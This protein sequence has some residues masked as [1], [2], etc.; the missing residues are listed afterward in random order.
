MDRRRARVALLT[1]VGIVLATFALVALP[2]GTPGGVGLAQAATIDTSDAII[3]FGE[4]IHVAPGERVETAVSFGGNILVEGTVDQAVV[5]F[6][7]NVD[8]RPG[9]SVGSGLNND[10]PAV[11]IFG[12]ELTK[13][14]GASVAGGT[15]DASD[16]DWEWVG[17][18]GGTI[19]SVTPF[20]AGSVLGWGLGLVVWA[21]VGLIVVAIAPRQLRSVRRQL[22]ER[23]VASLGWG[24]LEALVLF[25]ILTLLLIITIIGI[26][27][28]IP[29]AIF[30]VP[31]LFLFG[32]ISAASLV[33]RRVL[34]SAGEHGD[35]LLLATVV[36]LA[37]FRVID[38]VPVLGS[39]VLIFVWLAGLGAT[40]SAIW[41]WQRGRRR[42]EP[43]PASTQE[44]VGTAP[45]ESAA[46]PSDTEA[47]TA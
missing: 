13:A 2:A 23:P 6:G 10:D 27:V 22:E 25:P 3:T 45:V 35:D 29:W 40:V 30:V 32:Y 20:G 12:G 9:A 7:G 28:A 17:D 5:A 1:A 21:I 24:A 4:N 42:P 39:I 38:L 36:G 33:G 14:P 34:A 47:T 46:K 15:V 43:T 44:A 41:R 16:F 8:L 11:V 31:L 18:I 37:I 26:I 19:A